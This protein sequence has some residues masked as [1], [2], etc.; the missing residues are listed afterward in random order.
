MHVHVVD[1]CTYSCSYLPS[2]L[3]RKRP[4]NAFA[5][6]SDSDDEHETAPEKRLRLAKEYL[7]RLEA[8]G[9]RDI[10]DLIDVAFP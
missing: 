6:E 1:S 9:M 10:S 7:A 4:R 2:E 5:R 3:E 8:A